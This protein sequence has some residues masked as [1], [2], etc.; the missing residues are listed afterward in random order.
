MKI[1]SNEY[2]IKIFKIIFLKI[3]VHD[4]ISAVYII[5]SSRSMY[6]KL[7]QHYNHKA[8]KTFTMYCLKFIFKHKF[9]DNLKAF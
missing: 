4:L 2:K 1:N 7:I 9:H 6:I 5:K 8:F 3:H